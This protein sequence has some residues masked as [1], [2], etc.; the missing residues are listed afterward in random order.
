MVITH[1]TFANE[2]YIDVQTHM[3]SKNNVCKYIDLKIYM[4]SAHHQ[5]NNQPRH[6]RRRRNKA[7]INWKLGPNLSGY[8]DIHD[9]VEWWGTKKLHINE[10]GNNMKS[11]SSPAKINNQLQQIE[12]K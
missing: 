6:A 2:I 1:L 8:K 4:D 7:C 10:G 12:M 5:N 9:G 11:A 3:D